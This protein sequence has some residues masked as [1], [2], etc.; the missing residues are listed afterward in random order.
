MSPMPL[1]LKQTSPLKPIV[2]LS[3][4]NSDTLDN[5]NVP[6]SQH[7]VS[8]KKL[9]VGV[10]LELPSELF[11]RSQ[12]K[13]EVTEYS[14]SVEPSMQSFVALASL[15][16]QTSPC[17]VVLVMKPLVCTKVGIQLLSGWEPMAIVK[18]VRRGSP[19]ARG[20]N[21]L[22]VFDRI[23]RVNDEEGSTSAEIASM[24]R[25]APAGILR[26]VVRRCQPQLQQAAKCLQSFW[27]RRNGARQVDVVKARGEDVLGI[28]FS[29]TWPKLAV[30]Q[31][32]SHK[33]L[34]RGILWPGD[35]V[36]SVNGESCAS[37]AHAAQM[38][39]D[40]CGTIS[41]IRWRARYLTSGDCK[42]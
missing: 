7:S 31:K 11:K 24:I 21:A 25:S 10:G 30:I 2:S 36:S 28:G 32:V 13:V 19:A 9:C 5:E 29:G 23:L 38:L 39:R 1:V 20:A 33:G 42:S 16:R 15:F 35:V 12:P 41:I 8:V 26:L 14:K 22:R 4:P 40:A 27:W 3:R 17:E 37:P 6:S 18:Q 34:A